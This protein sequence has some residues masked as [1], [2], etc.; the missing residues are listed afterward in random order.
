MSQEKR[1]FSRIVFDLPAELTVGDINFTTERLANLSVG[2]CLF[3]L[4]EEL[5]LGAECKLKISL[6]NTPEGLRVEVFGE[7]VRSDAGAISIKFTKIDPDSLFHLHNIVRYNTENPEQV[8]K[9]I[10][11]HPGLI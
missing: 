11:K 8:E 10:E 3:E 1:R 7:I 2:G 6:D 5:P 4:N 9:E